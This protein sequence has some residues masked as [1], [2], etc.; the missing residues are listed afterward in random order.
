LNNI[1]NFLCILSFKEYNDEELHYFFASMPPVPDINWMLLMAPT[2]LRKN[3]HI[4]ARI[5]TPN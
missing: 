2:L 3:I 5:F 4:Q 1:S